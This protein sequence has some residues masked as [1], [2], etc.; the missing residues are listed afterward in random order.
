[1]SQLL[2]QIFAN[3]M[4]KI[5]YEFIA[6]GSNISILQYNY[7]LSIHR[8]EIIF[9][10]RATQCTSIWIRYFP[11]TKRTLLS[12]YKLYSFDV[13]HTFIESTDLDSKLKD[14]SSVL[15]KV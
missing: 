15:L 7:D 2:S 4:L 6:V 9:F 12:M 3:L 5:T 1:M 14:Y 8:S 13:W 10:F 11:A